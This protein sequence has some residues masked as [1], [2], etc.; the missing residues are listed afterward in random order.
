VTSHQPLHCPA[1]SY[2]LG[3]VQADS[4]ACPECGAQFVRSALAAAQRA[5]VSLAL[6]LLSFGAL[7]YV[8]MH[9]AGAAISYMPRANEGS[10]GDPVEASLV[11]GLLPS[12][13]VAY[14]V[15]TLAAATGR[16]QR[17]TRIVAG[18]FAG[19][20]T[21][22]LATAYGGGYTDYSPWIQP[23]QWRIVSDWILIFAEGL[24]II[25]GTAVLLRLTARR[26][27]AGFAAPLR[28]VRILAI[29]LILLRLLSRAHGVY[30]QY[31]MNQPG[32]YGRIQQSYFNTGAPAELLD[33]LATIAWWL[34]WPALGLLGLHIRAIWKATQ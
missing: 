15:C 24:I 8:A 28:L 6:A 34:A 33:T 4:G 5:A 11:L 30:T 23:Y 20:A 3:A 9:A 22:R 32:W 12:L 25:A 26:G 21:L 1:C 7:A 31:I 17:W 16:E 19:G 18:V 13:G 29:A 10:S 27:I 14:A 2:D